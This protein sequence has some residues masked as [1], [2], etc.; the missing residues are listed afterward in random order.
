MIV[1]WRVTQR[2]NL[3][4]P[5]CAWDKRL[6]GQRVDISGEAVLRFARLLGDYQR[7]RNDPVLLSWLG[8]EPLLWPPLFG[9]AP[10]IAALGIAQSATT[11]GTTLN[12]ARRRSQI[13]ENFSELTVSVDGFAPFHESMRGW[14]GGWAQLHE[15]VAALVL[16]RRRSPARATALKLRANIVLMRDNLTQFDELCL[17]LADWGIDEITFNALG[18]RDRPEFFPAHRWTPEDADGFLH[19]LPALK[20]R[21]AVQ[22]VRLCAAPKYLSRLDASARNE[23]L[24]VHDC[25]PGERFLFIDEYG[26]IAPCSFTSDAYGVSIADLTSGSDLAN[27]AARFRTDRLDAP[28][29]VCKDC[30]STHVFAKFFA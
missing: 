13:L 21:L 25:A 2:C 27:L 9:L 16:E 28:Q 8:G 4:C 17:T 7:Q 10:R 23:S 11:N 1:V 12:S 14:P 19:R 5:F 30:P 26:R 18:G 3:S 29:P 15:A 6:P 20:A 22:G 24:P